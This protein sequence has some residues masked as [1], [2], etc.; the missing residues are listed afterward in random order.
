MGV[1]EPSE[2]SFDSQVGGAL[3]ESACKQND[4]LPIESK[5]PSHL[6]NLG[7][8]LWYESIKIKKPARILTV[9]LCIFYTVSSKINYV[10]VTCSPCAHIGNIRQKDFSQLSLPCISDPKNLTPLHVVGMSVPFPPKEDSLVFYLTSTHMH[11]AHTPAYSDT[12][13]SLDR[14]FDSFSFC[15]GEWS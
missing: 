6:S 7:H 5:F 10:P 15:R 2:M 9:T 4:W 8:C 11:T 1:H 3:K 13:D 12:G 14:T